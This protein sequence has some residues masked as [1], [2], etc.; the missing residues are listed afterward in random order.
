MDARLTRPLTK[1]IFTVLLKRQLCISLSDFDYVVRRKS[2]GRAPLSN[3][4]TFH[5]ERQIENC[6][7]TEMGIIFLTS[8]CFHHYLFHMAC[9]LHLSS[10]GSDLSPQLR[11]EHKSLIERQEEEHVF[12]CEGEIFGKTEEYEFS[13]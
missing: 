1:Y 7:E 10:W 4:L 12:R 2:I 6:H 8:L 13:K 11:K 5:P 3:N 9:K